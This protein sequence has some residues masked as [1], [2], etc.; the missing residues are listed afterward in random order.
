MWSE[1][2]INLCNNSTK[3]CSHFLLFFQ[4]TQVSARKVLFEKDYHSRRTLRQLCNRKEKHKLQHGFL[5]YRAI[6]KFHVIKTWLQIKWFSFPKR[7]IIRKQL[8]LKIG[9]TSFALGLQVLGPDNSREFQTLARKSW[10]LSVN[11]SWK[12]LCKESCHLRIISYCS[13]FPE[14]QT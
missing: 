4:K 10:H 2:R 12:K 1:K 5:L 3:N 14:Q 6:G 8:M 11:S 7:N 13:F 9:S